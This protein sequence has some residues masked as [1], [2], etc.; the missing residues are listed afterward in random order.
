VRL[1]IEEMTARG[2]H[3]AS[4]PRLRDG[5]DGVI[6]LAT[7]RAR[8]RVRQCLFT[9]AVR[10]ARVHTRE[11]AHAILHQWQGRVSQVSLPKSNT[12]AVTFCRPDQL[13]RFRLILPL[14]GHPLLDETEEVD[15][16]RR[17][18]AEPNEGIQREERYSGNPWAERAVRG[19]QGTLA[20]TDE[21][22]REWRLPPPL[23]PRQE[24]WYI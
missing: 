9:R 10:V 3:E 15:W 5:L 13:H 19:E 17:L 8:D 4:Q 14:P 24:G 22:V 11:T 23:P 16:G 1:A 7:D 18:G 2:A 21:M 6:D 20:G 12:V